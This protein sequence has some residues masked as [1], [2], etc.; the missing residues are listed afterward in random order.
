MTPEEHY[1]K[2]ENMYHIAPC[3][4]Y[5]NPT[6]TVGEGKAEIVIPVKE[7]LFHAAG[8]VHGVTYFKALDD[9]AFFSANSLVTKMFV[10]TANFTIYLTRPISSGSMRAIGSVVNTTRSQ[11]IAESI[12]YDSKDREIARGMGSF[13]RSAIE[14]TREI[15]YK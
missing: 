7:S 12:L 9:A 15:G 14:L 2:L 5:Y 1:R 6:L 11:F 13:V 3:N 4:E 10:L 8:A